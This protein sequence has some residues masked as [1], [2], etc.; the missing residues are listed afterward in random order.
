MI[1]SPH[2]NAGQDH[3]LLIANA[4][5]ENVADFM[6]LG[7]TVTHQ[8]CIREEIN[9]R[10]NSRNACYHSV[11]NHISSRFLSQNLT[12]KIKKTC[13]FVWVCNFVSYS[14]GSI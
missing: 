14:K 2:Q 1:V 8:N 12:I 9:G 13:C 6:N 3:D 10:L 5:F 7:T 11:Q 4:S